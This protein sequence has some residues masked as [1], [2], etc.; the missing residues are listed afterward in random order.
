MATEISES[1]GASKVFNIVLLITHHRN[2]DSAYVQQ[3]AEIKYPGARE[4]TRPAK[5]QQEFN[6]QLKVTNIPTSLVTVF[7]VFKR[8]LRVGKWPRSNVWFGFWFQ[9]F[10]SSFPRLEFDTGR[11]SS[12]RTYTGSEFHAD[13]ESLARASYRRRTVLSIWYGKRSLRDIEPDKP[14]QHKMW[15]FQ[16]A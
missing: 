2:G 3:I 8:I 9:D 14:L 11:H 4:G 1:L 12:A 5:R 15:P 13:A 16:Q 7:L 6:M 10:A